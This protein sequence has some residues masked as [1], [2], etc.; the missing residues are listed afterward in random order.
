M[1][2]KYDLAENIIELL[3]NH[4]GLR[5]FGVGLN[6]AMAHDRATGGKMS[7][8][9]LNSIFKSID[10]FNEISKKYKK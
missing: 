4:V 3:I 9:D 6:N 10:E 5:A 1:K 8:K 7:S 2:T